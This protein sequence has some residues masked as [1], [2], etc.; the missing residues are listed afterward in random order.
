MKRDLDLVRQLLFDIE[1]HGA[2]CAIT[3]LRPNLAE[4]ADQRIRYHLRLLIDAQLVKELDRDA[5][6]APCVRLTNSGHELLEL[7]RVD[8]R[9]HEARRCAAE[10]TG[11]ES[12]TV[13]RAVLTKWAVQ[14]AVHPA[15]S[16]YR[17]YR[18]MYHRVERPLHNGYYYEREPLVEEPLAENMRPRVSYRTRP[19][20][21]RFDW[22]DAYERDGYCTRYS[23]FAETEPGYEESGIGVSLPVSL[24]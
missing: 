10:E 21:E 15:A 24:V 17:R 13:I 18:P 23:D 9:W 3:A 6:G 11:G 12:L 14:G 22:R 19:W 20:R 2:S 7:S 16:A 5:N 8:T 1:A 4:G